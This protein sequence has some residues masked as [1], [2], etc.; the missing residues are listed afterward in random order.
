MVYSARCKKSL[1]VINLSP[2]FAKISLGVVD[3]LSF[4]HPIKTII[5]NNK[6]NGVNSGN[7]KSNANGI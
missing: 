2:T 3:K 1:D 6:R 4:S 7:L 5:A